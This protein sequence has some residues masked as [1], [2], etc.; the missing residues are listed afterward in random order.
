MTRATPYMLSAPAAALLVGLLLG[1]LVLLAR[2]SLYAPAGG[3]GYYLPGTWTTANLAAV[4]D[5]FGLRL[6]GFTVLFGC[7]VAVVSVAVGYPL[8][9]FIRA[10]TRPARRVAVA[11]LLAPKLASAL[12]V[13]FGLQ[14]LL[15]AAGPVSRSLVAVGAV[16]EPA[17]LSRTL[18]AALLGEVYL[19]LPYAAL[20]IL[21]QFGRIDPAVEA[22]ARGL[23]AGRW[24]AFRRVT[25]P[26]SLPGVALAGQLA[27]MW[28]VGAFFGPLFLGSPGRGDV[29]RRGRTAGLL[30]PPVAAGGGRGG[31]GPAGGG[32]RVRGA[33]RHG[34]PG[35]RP[36]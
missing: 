22:A 8:A 17:T 12:V 24:Q 14:Q 29:G 35:R 9:L 36:A 3:R 33:R 31:A 25:L 26:L 21:L 1:P 15:S 4:A 20:V 2:M 13:M 32:D 23:G 28:G 30:L 19:V 11:V 27:L 5:A 18:G 6:L 7:G 34:P 16:D 10:L